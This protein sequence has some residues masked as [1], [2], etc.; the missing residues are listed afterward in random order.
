MADKKANIKKEAVGRGK[1]SYILELDSIYVDPSWNERNMKRG[2]VREH[3]RQLARSIAEVGQKEPCTVV[4]RGDKIALTDGFCRYA[5][6]KIAIEEHGADLKGLEVKGEGK[7]TDEADHVASML[8]RNAGLS[9][10]FSEQARVVKRLLAFGWSKA[11]IAARAMVSPT[12]VD[13]CIILLEA[14]E[15]GA[16]MKMLDK[17]EVSARLAIKT[18]REKPKAPGAHL[19]S[20]IKKANSKGKSKATGRTAKGSLGQPI[21]T[22]DGKGIQWA[23]HGPVFFE[24][25]EL[26]VKE[27]DAAETVPDGIADIVNHYRNYKDDKKLTASAG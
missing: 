20:E 21:E 23:K 15:G 17:G 5:A 2:E 18:I 22:R 14:N 11:E 13:N 24:M 10:S 4:A 25:L 19:E 7:G 9:L 27:Y 12:H 16:I 3:I 6:V 1:E 26:L 8:V